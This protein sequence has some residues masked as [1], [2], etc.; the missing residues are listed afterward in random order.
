MIPLVTASEPGTE[1]ISVNMWNGLQGAWQLALFGFGYKAYDWYE[2]WAKETLPEREAYP[3]ISYQW[4]Q[5]HAFDT[6]EFRAWKWISDT[7]LVANSVHW[8]FWLLNYLFDNAGGDLHRVYHSL[9][10]ISRFYPAVLGLLFI[11]LYA[12]Y[13]PSATVEAYYVDR[14]SGADYATTN[15]AWKEAGFFHRFTPVTNAP[16]WYDVKE[17]SHQLY[18]ALATLSAALFNYYA[19]PGLI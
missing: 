12:N 9:N 4:D 15:A 6:N 2:G 11:N 13:Y 1:T 14:Y 7:M 19:L 8:T 3:T 16:Y 18:F 10:C 5:Q 17:T